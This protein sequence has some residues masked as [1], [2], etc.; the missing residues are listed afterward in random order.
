[1]SAHRRPRQQASARE[2]SKRV[3]RPSAGAFVWR[4]QLILRGRRG[5]YGI[6]RLATGLHCEPPAPR[7]SPFSTEMQGLWL[8]PLSDAPSGWYVARRKGGAPGRSAHLLYAG[9]L[10]DDDAQKQQQQ[11]RHS[12]DLLPGH[13][14]PALPVSRKSIFRDGATGLP[15]APAQS[16]LTLSGA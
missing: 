16:A 11:V 12:N 10:V 14:T 13:P 3:S 4:K 1:L 8:P 5:I 7:T 9:V 2:V 15:P 6:S